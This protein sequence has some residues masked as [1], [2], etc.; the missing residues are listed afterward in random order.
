M[1]SVFSMLSEGAGKK[2]VFVIIIV[3]MIII[4]IVVVIII[5]KITVVILIISE[6]HAHRS[7]GRRRL[8]LWL[9]VK[10]ALV[11]LLGHLLHS[12]PSCL[13]GRLAPRH[14]SGLWGCPGGRRLH[15]YSNHHALG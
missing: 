9:L 11:H 10:Q 7:R 8:F 6:G 14:Q 12:Q 3:I 15:T 2:F 13:T 5:I 1:S 4:V